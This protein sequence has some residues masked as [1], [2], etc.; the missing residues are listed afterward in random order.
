M[1]ETGK[2][3]EVGKYP[4]FKQGR[5]TTVRTTTAIYLSWFDPNG[6]AVIPKNMAALKPDIPLLWLVGNRDIMA[7]YGKAY[8]FNRAPH[9][10]DHRYVEIRA[11]HRS[12]P[13]QG[14]SQ[15]IQWIREV[16]R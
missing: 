8:A 7:K 9:H 10:P 2:G 5:S 13:E 16:A 15:I 14:S 11:T 1:V 3:E 12:A 4:D 6:P